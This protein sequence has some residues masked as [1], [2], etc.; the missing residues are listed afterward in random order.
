MQIAKNKNKH[1]MSFSLKKKPTNPSPCYVSTREFG[2]SPFDLI[3]PMVSAAGQFNLYILL[4]LFG[5]ALQPTLSAM[6]SK[7]FLYD[8][9]T[10][11]A[12]GCHRTVANNKPMICFLYP[13]SVSG[14]GKLFAIQEQYVP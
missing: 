14:G 1:N 12:E 10:I 11:L 5:F 8:R 2:S 3:L 9:Q 4:M 6:G 13:Q 7:H